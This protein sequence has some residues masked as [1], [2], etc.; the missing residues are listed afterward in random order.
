MNEKLENFKI[1][2]KQFDIN[3]TQEELY[4]EIT[5]LDR[6]EII[7][8]IYNF[9]YT[10]NNTTLLPAIKILNQYQNAEI[11]YILGYIYHIGAGIEEPDTQQAIQHYTAAA[12]QQ[13]AKAQ[14][15][16]GSIYQQDT[17]IIKH[18][19]MSL[20]FFKEA[21]QQ[22]LAEAQYALG[23]IY[24][25][26][27]RSK[28]NDKKA[29]QWI[30]AA[31]KQGIAEAQLHL[32]S[33]YTHGKGVEIC[34]KT[35]IKW[36]KL[37]AEQSLPKAQC[38]LGIMYLEAKG[39]NKD[40]KEAEK[41]LKLAANQGYNIAQLKLGLM[42][43]HETE[44]IGSSTRAAYW[45]HKAAKQPG[46]AEA[47]LH[48]ASLYRHGQGVVQNFIT[49]KKWLIKAANAGLTEAQYDLGLLYV[50]AKNI[51]TALSWFKLAANQHEKA[52]DYI[53]NH[54]IELINQSSNYDEA[55]KHYKAAKQYNIASILNDIIEAWYKKSLEYNILDPSIKY[56]NKTGDNIIK[57]FILKNSG[58]LLEIIDAQEDINQIDKKFFTNLSNLYIS[59]TQIA[60]AAI[61]VIIDNLL[62]NRKIKH[63]EQC[64]LFT[65]VSSIITERSRNIINKI[66]TISK[67]IEK[68]GSPNASNKQLLEVI[69]ETFAS[70]M[71][72]P[73]DPPT[74]IIQTLVSG[75]M[76]LKTNNDKLIKENKVLKRFI[77]ANTILDTEQERSSKKVKTTSP[78]TNLNITTIT[79][80][81]E[82]IKEKE[83]LSK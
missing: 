17:S 64:V 36:Y 71:I 55:T 62:K 38:F 3:I 18:Q 24:Q 41:W 46:L 12:K 51:N 82:E 14:Y 66:I 63:K 65:S 83:G 34:F 13:H 32:A 70:S 20:K 26:K 27:E 8:T 1:V 45:I 2:L 47:Q 40:L 72:E 44:E 30:N 56:L 57:Q 22:G 59:N 11:Q 52:A 25:S 73:T 15:A 29:A 54:I 5:P 75:I 39:V 16:L 77:S 58:R 4:K 19:K 78:A 9:L 80:N 48:L 53:K 33:L 37:A 61:Y 60:D 28:Y 67:D 81:K 68:E 69:F 23:C 50:Q 31:A 21:A 74:N 42:Y 76:K 79:S 6:S 49:A 7:A 43:L 10:N 35:A